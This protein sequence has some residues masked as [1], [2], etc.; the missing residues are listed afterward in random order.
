MSQGGASFKYR[1]GAKL[2]HHSQSQQRGGRLQIHE[3][4]VHLK[5]MED[6]LRPI[7][8]GNIGHEEPTPSSPTTWRAPRPR[9]SSPAPLTTNDHR[10]RA[11]CRYRGF[12]RNT[13]PSRLPLN[14][15]LDT[16]LTLAAGNCYRLLARRLARDEMAT[17]QPD[18]VPLPR[19]HL[20]R[21]GGRG[22]CPSRPG[23]SDLHP[24]AHRR[25]LPRARHRGPV[26][27]RAQLAFR[28]PAR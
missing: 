16:T 11:R 19:R 25:R 28:L 7:A 6:P 26:V 23:A 22:S 5:G 10:E 27:G 2:R 9:T 12:H 17:P 1:G 18:L 8:V 14:I 24:G 4:V 20:D 15:D 21:H 13:L 3:E